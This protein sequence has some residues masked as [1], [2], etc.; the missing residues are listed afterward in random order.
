MKRIAFT[1][2]DANNMKYA[3]KLK[4]SLA[5]FHPDLELR[6]FGPEEL[7][8][9]DDKDIFY[10]Q[11]PYFANIL[12]NEGYDEVLGLDAD[13]LILGDISY[14]FDISADV[15]VVLNFNPLDFKTY[16]PITVNPIHYATEYFNCGLVMMKSHK[17]VKHWL[18]LCNGPMF[19]RLT[20]REQD[21]LNLILYFGEYE[22]ECYDDFT[23]VTAHAPAWHGLL[24]SSETMRAELR[25]KDIVVPMNKENGYPSQD[26]LFKVWHPAGGQG[27]HDKLNYHTKFQ[28]PVIQRINEILS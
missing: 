22:W 25:G 19:P 21:L 13:M 9:I 11:K 28:E 3:E 18:K 26:I 15:G 14:L 20:Y 24:A 2:A 7:A 6:V 12:F 23:S 8:K 10:K 27:N 4:K 16:G 17:L 1:V 5:Y